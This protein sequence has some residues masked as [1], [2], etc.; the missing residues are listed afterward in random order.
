MIKII[1]EK[2]WETNKLEEYNIKLSKGSHTEQ[3]Y[4]TVCLTR[5]LEASSFVGAEEMLRFRRTCMKFMF[6]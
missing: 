4:Y 6:L 1:I 2:A 5:D 3:V